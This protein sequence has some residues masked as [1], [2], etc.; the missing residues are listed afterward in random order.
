MSEKSAPCTVLYLR[1]KL[2]VSPEAFLAH[3][4]EAAGIIASVDG[5]IWKTW[6]LNQEELEMGGMYLFASRETAEAYLNHPLVQAVR[7]NPAVV[8]SHS[9]LWDVE[10]SLSAVTRAPLG[11]MRTQSEPDAI[12]AGGR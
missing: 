5:L 11:G 4:R 12:M 1:H 10:P 9:Q 2:R 7:S 6:L 8:S 3:S